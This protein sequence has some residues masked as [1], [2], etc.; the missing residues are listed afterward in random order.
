MAYDKN[1]KE[2][3]LP[4]GSDPKKRQ[5][6]AFL[7]KYFRTPVNEKFLH[8]TVDHLL[9]PGSVQKLSAYYGRKSSKA[10]STSEVYVPDVSSD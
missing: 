2:Y 9:S 7:P 10:Y 6:A 4:A 8:S 1:Q 3:P 5:T